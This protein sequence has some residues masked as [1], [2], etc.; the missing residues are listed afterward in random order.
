M[1]KQKCNICSL[2]T[3]KRVCM[4]EADVLICPKCC[5][6]TRS[7]VCEGC[8]FYDEAKKYEENKLLGVTPRP[9]EYEQKKTDPEFTVYLD[10]DLDDK[11]DNALMIAER[12]IDEGQRLMTNLFIKHPNYHTVLYGIG[13]IHILQNEENKA[14]PYFEKAVKINPIFTEAWFNKGTIHQRRLEIKEMIEAYRNVIEFGEPKDKNVRYANKIIIRLEKSLKKEG[15]TLDEHSSLMDIY[16]DA[17]NDLK[18]GNYNKAV[19]GFNQVIAKYP[20]HVQSYGN[21][22]LCYGILGLK[23]EALKTLDK[24]LELDP[25]YEPAIINRKVVASLKEGEKIPDSSSLSVDYY[26][27]LSRNK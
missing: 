26:K 12:N 25:K 4:I 10:P 2:R 13:V 19:D 8:Y 27:D 9:L 20:T 17:F 18:K 1:K 23:Q 24:A 16:N 21:L 5:A 22:G 7:S 6:K 15:F 14:L 11:V 3:G